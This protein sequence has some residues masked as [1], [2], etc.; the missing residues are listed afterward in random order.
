M[1]I[2]YGVFAIRGVDFSIIFVAKNEG[3]VVILV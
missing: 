2:E 3:R 1:V